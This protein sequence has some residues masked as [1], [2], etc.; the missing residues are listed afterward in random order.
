ME[1]NTVCTLLINALK[2]AGYNDSTIFNYQGVVRRFKTF[3][4]EHDVTEYSCEIGNL[5]AD[6]IISPKTGKFS[7][8][9][10][11]LQGRFI[12][13]IDS[14]IRTGQFDF[15][16]TS[17]SRLQPENAYYRKVYT[18]YCSYLKDQYENENTRHFYEYGMYA[19]LSF[20]EKR[21]DVIQLEDLT[22]SI[23]LDYVKHS[24]PERQRG[25]LCELRKI[26]RYLERNDLLTALSG[27]HAP[28][29]H[30]IIPVLEVEEQERI[31][32]VT[33]DDAT[34]LRDSAMILLGLSTGIRACDIIKLRLTDID[35][36]N[37][38]ISWRQSKTGNL[39]CVPLTPPV[40]N[41]VARYLTTQR[42]HAPN[43]Y[44]FVRLIAPFDPL[45]CH[46]SCYMMVK[47]ILERASI[48][49]DN[50]IL[51]M[52][53]LRHNAASTMVRNEV[54]VETIASIL[55]HVDPNTTGI[56][57]TTDEN[58]LK[59]CVLPFGGISR[60]VHT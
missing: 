34:P 60:E 16:T 45:S 33:D 50:R 48:S 37:D 53:M 27:I 11:H 54:P 28:R 49:T 1:I 46:S 56:Y 14:F 13:L 55:G 15:S 17:R 43:D 51:G 36:R 30:R 5:Y 39:V 20:L 4:K 32:S 21:E 8:S 2:D 10:Y 22:A 35:W 18:D 3:C 19:F 7:K 52:H 40:G 31:K 24:K 59:D 29:H 38:T 23:F 26:C 41:A 6:F 25:V 58:R 44:L 57:I 12:R 42:P 47:R 9:R